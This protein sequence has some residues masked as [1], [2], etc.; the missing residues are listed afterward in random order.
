MNKGMRHRLL[1]LF[2]LAFIIIFATQSTAP[3]AAPQ[4][5]DDAPVVARVTLRDARDVGRF[6]QLG[7]DLLEMRQGDDL[8]ILTSNAQIKEL[9]G[10][11]WVIQVD[12][13]Q[14]D[15]FSQQ[16]KTNTYSGG[17]RTVA[18][19]RAYVDSKATQYPNLAEV[20][21]YG[22]SWEKV[23]SGGTSGS[24]LFG[25]TLTNRQITGPK[26]TFF[27]MAAIH[28]RE[29][30]TSELALRFVDYL[31]TNYGTDGDVTWLLD[32]H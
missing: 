29:L 11:G 23:H 1:L 8:F 10:Q 3:L 25:I 20:F 30:T 28:A 16:R 31:L 6:V 27:L 17:Y 7:L 32:E 22:Q 21:T 24:D 14:T 26:P 2:I 15:L 19:M 9:R 13:Q 18:E 4:T 12:P 5:A